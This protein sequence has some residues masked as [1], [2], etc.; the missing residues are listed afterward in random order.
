M[1][2]D[3]LIAL[4]ARADAGF[5]GRPF[6]AMPA[7]DRKRYI[8]R[9][10]AALAAIEAAG[11]RVVPEDY[12]PANVALRDAFI[13]REGLWQKFIDH[14]SSAAQDDSTMEKSNDAET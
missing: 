11:M 8:A 2:R 3:E 13:V 9:S 7:A 1:T 10:T 12:T 14:L 6:E 5:D 4:M